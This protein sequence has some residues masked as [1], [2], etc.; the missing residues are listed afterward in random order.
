MYIVGHCY[1]AESSGVF[2]SELP[3][4]TGIGA[5]ML[6]DYVNCHNW[7]YDNYAIL[8]GC[9]GMLVRAHLITDWVVHFGSSFTSPRLRR[10]WAYR[11]LKLSASFYEEFFSRA[12]AEGVSK[13]PVPKDSKR[14][15][16]HSMME[17]AIDSALCRRGWF[18]SRFEVGTNM[19]LQALNLHTVKKSLCKLCIPLDEGTDLEIELA[20]Y[21]NRLRMARDPEDFALL[22][23]ARKF[24]L[25][26]STES[27]DF[28]RQYI[29]HL[30]EEV[31]NNEIEAVCHECAEAVSNLCKWPEDA[32][33]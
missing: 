28:V 32:A 25:I 23:A 2:P 12:Y 8:T 10:G 18:D 15:F 17:Y 9:D 26:V 5:L 3:S 22:A 16:S 1:I 19:A 31:D 20:S 24:G 30:L 13:S 33:L 14:G 27:A 11:R 4:T 6:P 7:G 29:S 21:A